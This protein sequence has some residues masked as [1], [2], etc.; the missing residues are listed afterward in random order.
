MS[1]TKKEERD[2]LVKRWLDSCQKDDTRYSYATAFKLYVEFTNLDARAM[3]EEAQADA[4]KD[5]FKK[6]NIVQSRVLSFYKWLIEEAPRTRAGGKGVRVEVGK[7]YLPTSARNYAMAI[8]SF[9]AHYGFPIKLAG[10]SKIGKSKVTYRRKL[11]NSA[12]VKKLVDNARSPRDRA[13]ILTLFQGGMD[14]STLCALN[15]GDVAEGIEKNERPLKLNIFREKADV[16][17]YSF[18][19]LDAVEAI[20]IYLAD[21][22]SK[23]IIF[24]Y[25]TPLFLKEKSTERIQTN[26]VQMFFKEIADRAGFTD[27]SS[28]GYNL[29]GPHSLRESFSSILINKGVPDAIV[30]FLLGH[31]LGQMGEAYKRGKFEDVQ[32]M[33]LDNEVYLSM[34]GTNGESKKN[35]EEM[36]AKIKTMEEENKPYQE[37]VNALLDDKIRMEKKL[38]GD[39]RGVG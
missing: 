11:L 15:Y 25:S 9:Y 30:D 8:R 27:G 12:Q 2:E 29:Y 5:V 21:M 3:I 13:I 22:R 14:V 7:G 19:G 37:R 16:E 36:E 39:F 23:D 10:R 1:R 18:L 28:N 34:P 32:K 24:D 26:N 6:E 31:S 17:Y 35:I 38:E 20:K 33:Y 4:G